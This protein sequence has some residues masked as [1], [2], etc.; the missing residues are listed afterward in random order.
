MITTSSSPT[1]SLA[2]MARRMPQATVTTTASSTTETTTFTK[3][4]A[5]VLLHTDEAI[6]MQ[7]ATMS[8]YAARQSPRMTQPDETV[9]SCTQ[10]HHAR[11]VEETPRVS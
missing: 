5:S 8:R 1:T 3:I 4:H 6:P 11:A 9:R 2:R 7:L 10:T